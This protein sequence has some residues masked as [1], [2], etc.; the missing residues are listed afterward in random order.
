MSWGG[1]YRQGM[2]YTAGGVDDP[3]AA[4]D[5]GLLF[6][7][8]AADGDEIENALRR[9]AGEVNK[10]TGQSTGADRLFEI[11]KAVSAAYFFAPSLAELAG[12]CGQPPPQLGRQ[13][14][15]DVGPGGIELPGEGRGSGAGG[16][17]GPVEVLRCPNCCETSRFS[18]PVGSELG[19]CA[20]CL[21]LFPRAELLQPE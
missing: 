9:M 3:S 16:I 6:V 10:F 1:F 17:S 2:P 14:H 13:P 12:L 19:R 15:P 18:V 20:L 8:A 5:A 7:A 4:V 21:R 11:T